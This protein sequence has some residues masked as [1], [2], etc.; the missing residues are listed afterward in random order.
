MAASR[1]VERVLRIRSAVNWSGRGGSHAEYTSSARIF[2]GSEDQRTVSGRQRSTRSRSPGR[3][4][5]SMACPRRVPGRRCDRRCSSRDGAVRP[6][7]ELEACQAEDEDDGETRLD[8]NQRACLPTARGNGP[9]NVA[10]TLPVGN[11]GALRSAALRASPG[12]G[13]QLGAARAVDER[14]VLRPAGAAQAQ[15]F[16]MLPTTFTNPHMNATRLERPA[17]MARA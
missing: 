14:R 2:G 13:D 16:A 6:G 15:N 10:R 17:A 8:G 7:R 12:V 4:T 5:R 1:M 9:E 11:N 3:G